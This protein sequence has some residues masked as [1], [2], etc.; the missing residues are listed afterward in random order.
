MKLTGTPFFIVTILLFIGS[1]ALAMIQWRAAARSGADTGTGT[2][3]GTRRSRGASGG[4]T[5]LR[6]LAHFATILLCQ[7]SAVAMVFVMV[8]NSTLLYDSW[9]DLLGT[10]NHVRAVPVPPK[11]NGLAGDRAPGA[12]GA[13]AP[14]KV[15]Q[16]FHAPDTDAV[17]RE[18]KQADLKGRLSGV[19]G[20]VLVW[21]P[22]Q[23][24]DP[25]FKDKTFP[26][27]ELLAGYPG[28][29]SAWFGSTMDAISQLSPLMKTG[30]VT[31]FI[32]VAP[33]VKLLEQADTGCAD[34]PGKIN[35]ETW[36]ARDVPQ[37]VI[38]NF[39]AGTTADQWAVDGYSAGAHCALRLALGHPDRFRAAISMS[40]YN[41]PHEEPASLT[42]NDPKL[43][44]TANPLYLLTH[45]T[46]P[47]NVALYVTGK[48]G[49]GL[50]DAIALQKAAKAPTAVTPV[51]TTG[52]HLTT[53]W[54]P[55]VVPTFKWLS[56]II[57]APH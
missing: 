11:D 3:A 35:A 16:A 36:F 37:M 34:V 39:R 52:P 2:G 38:D 45:A 28:S 9:G 31:P 17:P 29:S 21:T 7:F 54:K 1:I 49:D 26:V 50:E 56:T 8:N 47:P 12:G 41:D 33:R 32:L 18:V 4:R 57:P 44:E 14:P 42:A 51:E 43:R 55:M 24:D 23:Y 20:E 22:P 46:T 25:A 15:V 19:D 5:P 40:G 30:Q 53:T 27:V 48:K 6:A 13:S 10:S